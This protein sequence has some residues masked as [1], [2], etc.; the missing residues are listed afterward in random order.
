MKKIVVIIVSVF[1]LCLVCGGLFYWRQNQS[2]VGALNKTLPIGIRVIKSL[3]GNGYGIINKIDGYQ[4]VIPP[5]WNGLNEI[6]YVPE[7]IENDLRV[8]GIELAAKEKENGVA[9]INRFFT[10]TTIQ[11]LNNWVENAIESFGLVGSLTENNVSGIKTIKIQENIHLGGMYVYFWQ[12]GLS[13]YAITNGSEEFI[14]YIIANG[15][16]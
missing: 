1:V 9:T 12:K 13:I 3:F 5:Q 4:F 10:N 7:R 2:D 14:R 8:A 6:A 11:D 15:K 16:W